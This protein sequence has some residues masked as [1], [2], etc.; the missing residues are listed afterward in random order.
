MSSLWHGKRL[1]WQ[2]SLRDPNKVYTWWPDLQLSVLRCNAACM[3]V[4]A[5]ANFFFS[6][7]VMKCGPETE[8]TD[9]SR[10]ISSEKWSGSFLE[11]ERGARISRTHSEQGCCCCS[12]VLRRSQLRL[13]FRHQDAS[14]MFRGEGLSGM[15][16]VPW[17]KT[18]TSCFSCGPG[19]P[20][21]FL[22]GELEEL[23]VLVWVDC[24]VCS[25]HAHPVSSLSPSPRLLLL[26]C[27]FSV[28]RDS[29]D[30]H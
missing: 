3:S 18:K 13:R 24:V 17:G 30:M 15:K 11:R 20:F 8:I 23:S 4:V 7:V 28:N 9:T 16:R 29:S 27:H 25:M 5:K 22:L 10:P 12:S 26:N 1:S 6:L 14:R 19:A 21:C 2:G